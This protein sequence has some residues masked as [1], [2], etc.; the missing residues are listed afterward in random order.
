[1]HP[2]PTPPSSA[3][4]Q[5]LLSFLQEYWFALQL[6]EGALVSLPG[7]DSFGTAPEI[8]VPAPWLPTEPQSSQAHTFVMF[9]RDAHGMSAG[10]LPAPHAVTVQPWKCSSRCR[11]GG[12]LLQEVQCL[13]CDQALSWA[14]V[15]QVM[16]VAWV[17]QE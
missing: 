4:F 12:S 14:V 6:P 2:C 8:S 13:T 7:C 16:C 9:V 5:P 1:M 17:H 3:S 15:E 11:T 10:P